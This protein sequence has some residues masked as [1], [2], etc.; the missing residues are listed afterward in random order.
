M[1]CKDCDGFCRQGRD[2]PHNTPLDLTAYQLRF[3]TL[4]QDIKRW[5]QKI[6]K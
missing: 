2:C 6:I 1:S 5:I 3:Y 4:I